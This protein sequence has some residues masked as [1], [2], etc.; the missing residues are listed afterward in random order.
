MKSRLHSRLHPP[1]LL[2]LILTLAAPGLALAQDDGGNNGL[3]NLQRNR[4]GPLPVLIYTAADV[5]GAN[6][7]GGGGGTATE[8]NVTMLVVYNTGFAV[9]TTTGEDIPGGGD[10]GES[11]VQTLQL[12]QNQFNDL[13]RSVRRAGGGRASGGAGAR[14]EDDGS[15]LVT[16]T[17]FQDAG[18]GRNQLATTFSFY[19]QDAL[20][21]NLG[22]ARNRVNNVLNNFLNTNFGGD[23]DDSGSGG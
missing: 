7:A 15:R 6:G 11:N 1:A 5:A 22:G 14:A 12:S 23:D 17:V 8:D 3:G 21:Q 18:D 20:Q 16:V 13:V 2:L 9:M 4:F 10:A 19:E